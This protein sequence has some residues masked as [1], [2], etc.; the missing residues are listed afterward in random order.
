M[1]HH[2]VPS[3]ACTE[4]VRRVWDYLDDEIDADLRERV[5]LH[6]DSCDHCREHYTFEGAFL[7]AL[8]RLVHDNDARTP[9]R[10]RIERA[11]IAHGIPRSE[12]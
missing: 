5:R 1:T 4:V 7:R 2:S 9:L 10:G 3:I 8:G 6:L 12:Q 11:L